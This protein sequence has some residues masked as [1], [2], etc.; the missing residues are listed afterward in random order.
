MAA[1]GL[2][3]HIQANRRRSVILLIGLFLLVYVLA[4]AG[5]LLAE[6]FL[7]GDVPLEYL[8][9]AAKYDFLKAVPFATIGALIWIAVA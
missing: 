3:T 5:A 6:V 4:F 9:Q 7:H 8:L 1:F 2:Y